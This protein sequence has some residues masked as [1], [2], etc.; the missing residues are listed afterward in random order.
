M[1]NK[2]SVIFVEG[3]RFFKPRENAPTWIKGNVVITLSELRD[4][5]KKHDIKDQ[6]RIDLCKSEKKGTYYWTL[7]TWK[8]TLKTPPEAINLDDF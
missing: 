1:E 8:P 6:L 5:I 7:N 3:I 4:F 2:K